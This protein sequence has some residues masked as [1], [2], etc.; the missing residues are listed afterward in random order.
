MVTVE[1]SEESRARER[2]LRTGTSSDTNLM[3]LKNTVL[4]Y[5]CAP[6]EEQPADP[7]AT[8]GDGRCV[9]KAAVT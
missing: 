2:T 8:L 5:M 3:Y 6:K 9:A 4:R 7:L 1:S